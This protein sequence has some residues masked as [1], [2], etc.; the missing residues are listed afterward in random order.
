MRL[1]TDRSTCIGAGL[2]ALAAPKV[3]A[4]TDDGL[5][6]PLVERVPEAELDGAYQAEELC[7]GRAIRLFKY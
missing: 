3:F 1:Q 5:V 6:R 4:Q 2:C 7:P